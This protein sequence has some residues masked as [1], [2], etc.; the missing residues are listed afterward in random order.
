MISNQLRLAKDGVVP[1][2]VDFIRALDQLEKKVKVDRTHTIPCVCGYSNDG[3]TIY[4]DRRMPHGFRDA[5]K[6][7]DVTKFL[8]L[9]EILESLLIR[10][11]GLQYQS[12][13]QIALRA[14][15][16]AVKAANIN[17]IAYI[18]WTSVWIKYL[19]HA[20]SSNPPKDLDRTPYKDEHD[21]EN[22]NKVTK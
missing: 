1:N 16:D 3:R 18:H 21:K 5:G 22:L 4:I 2:T 11:Y 6:F 7:V 9:H 20:D 17:V 15:L 10:T 8:I 13:H 14:E 12:A 19:E